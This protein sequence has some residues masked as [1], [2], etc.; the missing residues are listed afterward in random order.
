MNSEESVRAVIDVVSENKQLQS[1]I[2]DK[3]VEI[4]RLR[5]L[6]KE[7]KE[8]LVHTSSKY[9]QFMTEVDRITLRAIMEKLKQE[10]VCQ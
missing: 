7:V 2:T 9:G 10:G 6:L 8:E 5:S 4:L 1:T 3:D